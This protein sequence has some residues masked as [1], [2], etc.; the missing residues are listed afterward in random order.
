MVDK[1]EIK[2]YEGEFLGDDIARIEETAS[3]FGLEVRT[4]VTEGEYYTINVPDVRG[5]ERFYTKKVSPGGAFLEILYRFHIENIRNNFLETFAS[6]KRSTIQG[7][8]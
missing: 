4:V 3:L 7:N 6:K 2:I 8:E 1:V 5:K